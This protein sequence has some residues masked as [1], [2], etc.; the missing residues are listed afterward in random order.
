MLLTFGNYSINTTSLKRGIYPFLRLLPGAKLK[1]SGVLLFLLLSIYVKAQQADSSKTKE[2]HVRNVS[3]VSG[4][5]VDDVSGLPLPYISITFNGSRFGTTSD[6][7]GSFQLSA[8]GSF[9]RVTFSYVGYQAITKTIKPGQINT[10][11]IRL[12]SR[13]NQLKEVSVTSGKSKRY[14]NKGNPAVELIQQVI[15]HKEQNRM[16][17]ADYYQYDQYER[18]GLSL[19]HL[20]PRFINSKFFSKYRFMID[21][22]L[23]VNG[24][25]ESS[26]P[27]YFSEKLYQE[28]YRKKPEKTIRVLNAQKEVN[29]IK[30]IDTV[31]LDIYLNRLYGNNI[32]IYANNI[33][34]ITNQF[35][36]PIAD[37]SPEFYKFFITDTL[38]TDKGKL[39]EISFT[40][41]NKGDLLF[42]GRLLVTMDG[43]YAV[44]SC[45]LDV[46]KQINI[47]FMRSLKINLDFEQSSGGRYY[48]K[49]SDVIADF[50]ILRNKGSGVYGERTVTYNNYKLNA[51][52]AASFYNGKS[53][54]I[55]PNSNKPDTGYWMQHRS[56]SLTPQQANLYA[57]INRLESMPSF[58]RLTWIASTFTGGYADVGPVQI[59]P[60]GSFFSF[61]NQEGARF[62]LGG[63]TTPK[64]NSS[65]YLQGYAAYGT[66]D[67][68]FK[69]DLSTY[70]SLNKTAP[71]RY[72]NNYFKIS[73][74]YD[75]DL[76]GQT[77]AITNQQAALTS[78]HTGSTDYWI[79]SRILSVAY[80]KD[81]EN[82][83]SYNLA[84]RNWNQRA[85]GTLLFQSN[86]D[87]SII[88]DLS[89]TEVQVGL[90]YAPHEQIIQG[91]E[92]RHTIYSKYPI[93]NLQINHGFAGLL[94][95]VYNYNNISANI[96][97]RFYLSQLG[98]TDVTLLGNLITGKVPFPL[99][100]IPPANQ[101]LG[102]TPDAYNKMNYLEFVS[103][104]YVGINLTQSFNGFF[105]NKIP[106]IEHLKWRE[107]LSFKTIY[108]GLRNE[109]NP[110]FSNNL[111]KFPTGSG[112]VNGTY[113][114]GS[115]PYVE[116]G[117]GIGN[118]FKL[119]RIDVIKRFNY[120]DHPGITQYGIKFSITPDF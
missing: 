68:E 100:N 21:S 29:I 4:H 42:E 108:G 62:Q 81:L 66:K 93:F 63:R 102:Y 101:S 11:Q 71:Y 26:L 36:S 33:F 84:V 118:I 73:Y 14:R 120:L 104:H 31:G 8:P 49:K 109:N 65:V 48:L 9:S 91:T 24:H 44:E 85:A 23:Q 7:E 95:S 41:R 25:K 22:T 64:F 97:K 10:L 113:A 116:A 2:N 55:A 114:L 3:S 94:N 40:P 57:H 20:S 28:Y 92:Q 19:F 86:N 117:V 69:Y 72:P 58:K 115:T 103:D 77:Y 43:H 45:E 106:L 39:V 112:S 80:V 119:L 107:Y 12:R 35:L 70:F 17:A 75:V 82:H 87:N 99:L 16:E 78:F 88:H 53:L 83:F 51:P 110:L 105:L 52:Q 54:Q 18:I 79:Y 13:Q 1:R 27:V 38:Q 15:D 47:N 60:I 50:G 98:Y 111:Y 37:H 46:N 89:T 74:L 34:I 59:G 32:D 56:D 96:F 5:I 61:D 90:R 6:K 67:K 76:P 30:F